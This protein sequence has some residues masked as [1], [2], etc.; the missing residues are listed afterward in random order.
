MRPRRARR[1]PP[2]VGGVADE[3]EAGEGHPGDGDDDGEAAQP[4]PSRGTARDREPGG[5]GEPERAEGQDPFGRGDGEAGREPGGQLDGGPRDEGEHPR[6]GR[7]HEPRAGGEEQPRRRRGEQ[8]EH[9]DPAAGWAGLEADQVEDRDVGMEAEPERG[10]VVEAMRGGRRPGDEQHRGADPGEEGHA[11]AAQRGAEPAGDDRR[12]RRT[13]RRRAPR[14]PRPGGTRRWPRAVTMASPSSGR[15]PSAPRGVEAGGAHEQ[16]HEMRGQRV[17]DE[18]AEAPGGDRVARHGVHAVGE[19]GDDR[20]GGVGA[21]VA[22][23]PHAPSAPT[24]MAS[25]TSEREAEADTADEHRA[26]PG[27]QRERGWCRGGRAER[28]V[29]PRRRERAAA[30]AWIAGPARRSRRRPAPRRRRSRGSR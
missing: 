12:R 26:E 29:A 27:H 3:P 18:R 23:E 24:G 28:R 17:Q 5:D 4:E 8:P 16:Q 21:D 25:T 10:G 30:R 22:G 1:V 9:R 6:A 13:R 19:R 7:P 11:D 2:A 15:R 20:P 14:R